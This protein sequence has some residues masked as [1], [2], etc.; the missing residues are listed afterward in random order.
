MNLFKKFN[1]VLL[2]HLFKIYI[3]FIL[4]LFILVENLKPK[5]KIILKKFSYKHNNKLINKPNDKSN[6]LL[7]KE[8][9]NLMNLIIQNIGQNITYIHTLFLDHKRRF[10]NQF[11]ILNKAIF[12]CEILGCKKII[13]NKKY[14]WYI[15]HKI[16]NKKYKM[17]IDIGEEDNYKNKFTIFDKTYNFFY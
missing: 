14:F 13:L 8:K 10:G 4:I 2:K 15:K 3:F 9:S 6:P 17:I 5:I 1:N 11:I 7:Y 12:Y 16:I